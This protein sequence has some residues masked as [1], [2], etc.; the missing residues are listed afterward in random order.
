[1]SRAYFVGLDM[2]G[3]NL[4][5][6][7]VAPSGR[8]LFTHRAP[9]LAG[10]EAQEIVANICACIRS[11]EEEARRRGWG[12]ARAIGV[13][14]PGP[15]DLRRGTVM[16]APHVAAWRS[17]PLRARL[18][19]E[20]R[21]RITLEN[22]ANAWALG[23]FWRGSARRCRH[24]V[25][26][27]LGTGVGGAVVSN[28]KLVHG[29]AGM[30]GELGHVTVEPDGLR[31]DCGARGCLEAYAS[32][33]GL[34]AL[35]AQQPAHRESMPSRFLDAAGAF[36]VK[37]LAQAARSGDRL[38]R[39]VLA[40]AGRY[41]GIAIASFLNIFN[42]ELVVIGGGVAGAMPFMRAP[43]MREVRARAFAAALGN[44]RIARA[45]L[46]ERAGVVGAAYAAMNDAGSLS[47]RRGN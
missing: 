25:L 45:A 46:G 37:R 6:G 24:V 14:V 16:A 40:I 33:S 36:S 7:A 20:L 23:E 34:R 19:G 9:A 38:A 17:F 47:A 41:L 3:T 28:G 26:L 2:G 10:A 1:M 8:V 44:A 31:C 21:R 35:I 4:R 12:P 27:T 30:A 39:S 5:A 18:E 13:A 42:P 29:M 11:V 32:A 22:D 43:M 15:L